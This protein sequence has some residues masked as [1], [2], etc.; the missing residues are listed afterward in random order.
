[1]LAAAGLAV[2]A[3]AAAFLCCSANCSNALVE[4]SFRVRKPSMPFFFLGLVCCCCGCL[5]CDE[6]RL[7]PVV[8]AAMLLV[9]LEGCEE[10]LGARSRE[11]AECEEA[12][13]GALLSLIEVDLFRTASFGT[14]VAAVV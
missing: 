2:F 12:V 8:L 14:R 7:E 5:P 4:G 6:P 10:S 9:W 13:D 3:A 11:L 1:M